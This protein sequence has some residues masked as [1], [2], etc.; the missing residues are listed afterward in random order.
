MV[1]LSSAHYIID[2]VVFVVN[3][4]FGRFVCMLVYVSMVNESFFQ[5]KMR[6][7]LV[8]SKETP[9]SCIHRARRVNNPHI[10]LRDGLLI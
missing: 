9:Q 4:M 7:A 8:N 3:A 10:I 1:T 2:N 5:W 6:M